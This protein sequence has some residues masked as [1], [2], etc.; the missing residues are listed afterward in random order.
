LM[1]VRIPPSASLFYSRAR[2]TQAGRG[3]G[4]KTRKLKVQI[5]PRASAINFSCGALGKPDK[6][7]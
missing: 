3:G 5:F 2:V 1:W 7:A 4:L 6:A